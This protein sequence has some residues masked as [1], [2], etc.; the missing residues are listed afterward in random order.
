MNTPVVDGVLPASV[1]SAGAVAE[2]IDVSGEPAWVARMAELGLAAGSRVRML[3]PGQPC[4]LEVGGSRLSLRGDLT[5]H[6]LVR[7]LE[8]SGRVG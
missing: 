3:R 2:V 7:P 4:L 8:S 6:I 5:T 1:L